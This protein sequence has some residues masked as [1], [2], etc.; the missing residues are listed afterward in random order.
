MRDRTE[1]IL[2]KAYAHLRGNQIYAEIL[3]AIFKHENPYSLV[4]VLYYFSLHDVTIINHQN[5]Q[6]LIDHS[7]LDD[8]YMA[9][10]CLNR[11]G[12]LNFLTSQNR[13]FL[14]KAPEPI[15][16]A[17]KY[18]NF[19]KI[20]K[21]LTSNKI[22]INHQ[23][24]KAIFYHPNLDDL[25]L[26][27]SYLYKHQILGFISSKDLQIIFSR[28]IDI[29]AF[30]DLLTKYPNPLDFRNS[31]GAL[32]R[33]KISTP[34]NWRIL[35]TCPH[36]P[37]FVSNAIVRLQL[38]NIL[39]QKNFN[40]LLMEEH[41]ALLKPETCIV[42]A[43]FPINEDNYLKLLNASEQMNPIE[44]LKLITSQ[45]PGIT[46]P[47]FQHLN[48]LSYWKRENLTS[49]GGYL[50]DQELRNFSTTNRSFYS[51]FE[52]KLLYSKFLECIAY[53][54]QNR[55]ERLFQKI[56]KGQSKKIQEA[57]LYQARFNDYSGRTFNCSGYEYAWWAGDIR[58]CRMLQDY[59]NE[60]TKTLIL[61]RIETIL[62]NGG[63]S[64]QQN[65]ETYRSLHFDFE[66][67]K[68]AYQD[69]IG[70]AKKIDAMVAWSNVA[71]EQ[72][73]VPAHVAQ[74]FCQRGR[75]FNP[76]P[77]FGHEI[78]LRD[79]SIR[80]CLRT[81][82]AALASGGVFTHAILRA[83]ID[84]GAVYTDTIPLTMLQELA[85]MDL[86]AITSLEQIRTEEKLELLLPALQSSVIIEVD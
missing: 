18:I 39:N 29:I 51:L 61:T 19:Y 40:A 4:V 66:P 38:A 17:N 52:P 16:L 79:L 12:I 58:M 85:G 71:K 80:P 31:I 24:V 83:N 86:E 48:H 67:L 36:E 15:D 55:A 69:F 57:L 14:I 70:E 49:L 43:R 82:Y 53:G 32:S 8:L 11:R 42:W 28:D 84:D 77:N 1:S 64:F 10:S 50:S 47:K 34:D 56:F 6:V 13:K 30:L 73:K 35:L 81:W 25:C 75:S 63:L 9:F 72:Y 54:Q 22:N 21:Y 3:S 59:M 74:E 26:V 68:Q 45:I 65:H 33:A 76:L 23:D 5:L 20:N 62:A 2:E 7:S 78:L 46:F 37:P 60:E 27:L 41:S 44:Q